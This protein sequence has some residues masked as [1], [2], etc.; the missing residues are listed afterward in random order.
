LWAKISKKWPLFSQKSSANTELKFTKEQQTTNPYHL[1]CKQTT[2]TATMDTDINSSGDT[3]DAHIL[4]PSRNSRKRNTWTTAKGGLSYVLSMF[5]FSLH[6]TD[7][8]IVQAAKR[9]G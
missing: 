5:T 9:N 7:A 3:N 1:H 6:E 4:H 8:K 2:K